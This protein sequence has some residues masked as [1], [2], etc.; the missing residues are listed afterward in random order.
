MLAGSNAFRDPDDIAGAE[1][2]TRARPT[3]RHPPPAPS[4][5]WLL[6]DLFEGAGNRMALQAARAVVAEPGSAIQPARHRGRQRSGQDPPAACA[7]QRAR[8]QAQRSGR[9]SQRP[10]IHR[11]SSSRRS[12]AM[13]SARWRARYRTAVGLPARRCAPGGREGSDPGRA[14]RAVQFAD[15][16]R[17]ADDLHV[18]RAPGGHGG[19]RGAAPH[20]ARGR[21]GRGSAGARS[22]YPPAGASSDCSRPSW[23]SRP[24]ADQLSRL[25]SGRFDARACTAWSSE[26]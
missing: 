25:P 16:S 6:E 20:P 2:L 13:R 19:R 5:L 24:G 17:P 22:G 18:C 4:P 15:G 12:I 23:R 1:A 9:V 11:T 7:G 14:L 10:R 26:C 8:R 3:G 21:A